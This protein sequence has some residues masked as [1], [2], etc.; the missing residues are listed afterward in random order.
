M[1]MK[2]LENE[3]ERVDKSIKRV[4]LFDEVNE[5]EKKKTIPTM[6]PLVLQELKAKYQAKHT[7]GSS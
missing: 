7:E 6:N 4:S 5:R 2:R 3:Q 1:R